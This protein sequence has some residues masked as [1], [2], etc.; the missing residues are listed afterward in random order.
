MRQS[1]VRRERDAGRLA[2]GVGGLHPAQDEVGGLPL[3]DGG[4]CTSDDQGVV[5]RQVDPDRAIGA[6]R[7]AVD[8]R[9]VGL[10]VAHRHDDHLSLALGLLDLHGRLDGERVPLVELALDEVRIDLGRTRLE[11][12]LVVQRGDLLD[13]HHHP[14]HQRSSARSS[15]PRREGCRVSRR[16][17]K[18]SSG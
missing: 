13:R 10:L 12:E 9:L 4:Q 18:L 5:G 8:E 16:R 17:R 15:R 2:G 1:G 3:D 6:A 14:Q 11:L 7:Q